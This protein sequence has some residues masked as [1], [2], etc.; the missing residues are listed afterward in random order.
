LPWQFSLSQPVVG[1][2]M[3]LPRGVPL[4]IDWRD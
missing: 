2:V 4:P 3:L 1:S